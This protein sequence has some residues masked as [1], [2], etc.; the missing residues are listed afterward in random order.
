MGIEVLVYC[1]PMEEASEDVTGWDKMTIK[2]V[3]GHKSKVMAQ[4]RGMAKNIRKHNLQNTDVEDIYEDLMVYLY[5]VDDYNVNKAIERSKSGKMVSF[6][7]YVNSCIHFCVV[8]HCTD[9][10]ALE[11]EEIPDITSDEDGK[12]LS[13]FDTIADTKSSE[14]IETVLYDLEALCKSCEVLRYKYG[15]DIYMVWF[16]RLLTMKKENN[17]LYK[18]ILNILG[19]SKRELQQIEKSAAEDELMTSFA[20]AIE[21]VG[22]EKAISIIRPYIFSAKK[23]EDT[24]LAY[25]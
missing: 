4:I 9:M 6:E 13:L 23:I 18:N 19:V 2:Y 24:V 10:F 1:P 7:G 8:R 15:P 11:K 5:G 12:E 17:E 20:K 21:L 22:A 25:A 14:H 3:S 16:I